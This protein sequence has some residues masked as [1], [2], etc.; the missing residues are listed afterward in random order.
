MRTDDIPE[1]FTTYGP[2]LIRGQVPRWGDRDHIAWMR[3]REAILTGEQAVLFVQ[4]EDGATLPYGFNC[5]VCG[6]TN[7]LPRDMWK[8]CIDTLDMQCGENNDDGVYMHIGPPCL[9]RFRV[10]IEWDRRNIESCEVVMIHN[11]SQRP[12]QPKTGSLFQP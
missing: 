5:P 4:P 7:A 10:T 11:P 1:V 6:R 2:N 3:E 9:A 12:V 8:R